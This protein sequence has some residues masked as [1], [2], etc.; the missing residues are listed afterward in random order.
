[1]P[2]ITAIVVHVQGMR[3]QLFTVLAYSYT[4]CLKLFLAKEVAHFVIQYG[5]KWANL[6]TKQAN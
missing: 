1:M 4:V 6:T 3:R 5:M 2:F